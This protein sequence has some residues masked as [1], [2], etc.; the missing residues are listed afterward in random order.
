[1]HQE[2]PIIFPSCKANDLMFNLRRRERFHIC[3][4]MI[5]IEEHQEML[6]CNFLKKW[7]LEC[8]IRFQEANIN[9]SLLK[10]LDQSL[11]I[12]HLSLKQQVLTCACASSRMLSK[13]CEAVQPIE[14]E[15]LA[16]EAARRMY[17]MPSS[18]F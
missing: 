2:T 13:R 11:L 15:F 10:C 16:A 4:R 12:H 17:S 7:R 6:L 9:L 14:M 18:R 1:M 5:L 3:H 8:V